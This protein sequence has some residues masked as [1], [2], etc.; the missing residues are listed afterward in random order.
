VKFL[1][2]EIN[3]QSNAINKMQLQHAKSTIE[4]LPAINPS[5]SIAEAVREYLKD[6]EQVRKITRN[7][8]SPLEKLLNQLKPKLWNWNLENLIE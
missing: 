2:E 8:V 7:P 6:K 1:E 4:R 3:S 5:P